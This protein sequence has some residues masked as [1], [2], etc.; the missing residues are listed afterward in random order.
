M[1][2]PR[3]SRFLGPEGGTTT[4]ENRVPIGADTRVTTDRG[5]T[6]RP[7]GAVTG[8]TGTIQDVNRAFREGRGGAY[9][10]AG[11]YQVNPTG[12]TGTGTARVNRT[13]RSLQA[14]KRSF[15]VV[16]P[17]S[18]Q[19]REA[20]RLEQVRQRRIAETPFEVGQISQTVFTPPEGPAP[21]L[22]LPEFKTA[23]INTR[24]IN[25]LR[26][27]FSGASIQESRRNLQRAFARSFAAYGFNPI[28][29][30]ASMRIAL[31]GHGLNVSRALQSATTSAEAS[32]FKERQVEENERLIEHQRQTKIATESY[33]QALQAYE[34]TGTTKQ[35][36]SKILG[37]R[38]ESDR[39]FRIVSDLP[40]GVT[41]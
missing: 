18:F 16:N 15:T 4:P 7:A 3:P 33:R 8:R 36:T 38:D 2:T 32:Y 39:G 13:L 23:P 11:G 19:N 6:S 40:E 5:A 41:V 37:V 30:G 25:Q 14:A 24:R 17:N 20:R 10:V 1:A 9:S 34:R 27:Q 21:E 35:V 28:A 31:E 12:N 22:E 26:Q 29:R